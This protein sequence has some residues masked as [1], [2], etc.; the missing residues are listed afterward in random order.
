MKRVLWGIR[1][2]KGTEGDWGKANRMSL[3]EARRNNLF[4]RVV[5][6][7]LL[8]CLGVFICFMSVHIQYSPNPQVFTEKRTSVN[9]SSHCRPEEM[10]W[11]GT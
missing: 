10:L 2:A 6:L 11:S 4:L 9:I 8:V 7:V 5:F 1:G 3:P